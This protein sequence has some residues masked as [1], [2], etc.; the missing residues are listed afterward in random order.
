MGIGVMILGASGSGKSASM[1]NFKANELGVINVAGK[2]LPFRS[3][4][5]TINTDNYGMIKK[6]LTES[7]AQSIVIDDSQYLMADEY[8]RRASEKGFQKFTDIGYNFWDL[9]RFVNEIDDNKIVYF[10]QHTETD[11]NGIERAKTVGKMLNEK[12]TLEGMFTIVLKAEVVDGQY[13]FATKN[14][15]HDVVK[16]P[17]GM[18]DKDRIENDL[19]LVDTAIRGYFPFM[20]EAK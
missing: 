19:K 16:A 12:I 15:G 17:M 20:K 10:M 4:I 1:R 7:K 18:F 11:E 14:N 8:M 5:K 9:V 13:F 6:C 3:E 2:P